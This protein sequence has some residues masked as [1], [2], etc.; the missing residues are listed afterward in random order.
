VAQSP[1]VMLRLL[2]YVPMSH[3]AVL[4]LRPSGGAEALRIVT[5]HVSMPDS[6]LGYDTPFPGTLLWTVRSSL[7]GVRTLSN[8]F[9]L[10]YFGGP[11]HAHRGLV[12]SRLDGVVS[13]N[14][15]FT[16]HKIPLRPFSVRLRVAAQASC[17]HTVVRG[18][19]NPGYRQECI[20]IN[21]TKTSEY[22]LHSGSLITK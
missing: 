21:V 20:E 5:G 15:T 9:G 2:A 22:L 12:P 6:C 13:E 19:P 8:G 14:A 4:D 3:A 17:L 10:L 7:G 16:A 1:Y 11:G 18:T